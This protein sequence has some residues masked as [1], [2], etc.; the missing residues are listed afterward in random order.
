MLG[1]LET[2][3]TPTG[4]W[5]LLGAPRSKSGQDCHKDPLASPEAASCPLAPSAVLWGP[6]VLDHAS[7]LG[8][9]LTGWRA[10]ANWNEGL[11]QGPRQHLSHLLNLE[12]GNREAVGAESWTVLASKV[13]V[14]K[15]Y[16]EVSLSATQS[17]CVDICINVKMPE[18]GPTANTQKSKY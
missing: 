14:Y 6:T 8:G 11:C 7:V 18:D 3:G 5:K 16:S 1:Q 13:M 12:T 4:L 10:S 15:S 9:F 17:L 2:L